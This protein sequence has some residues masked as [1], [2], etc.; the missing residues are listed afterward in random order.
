MRF[1]ERHRRLDASV[2]RRRRL[3]DFN[4]ELLREL[5][6][7]VIVKFR[8]ATLLEHRNCR[9]LAADFRRK[10]A[11][12]NARR[13][14]RILYLPAKLWTQI[15]HN[16]NIMDFILSNDKGVLINKLYDIINISTAVNNKYQ[17]YM[18]TLLISS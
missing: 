13:L 17:H 10:F 1:G 15:F 18:I 6:D 5:F 8:A 2:V 11:L 4:A 9:L 14:A 16:P 7:D 12:P 3:D